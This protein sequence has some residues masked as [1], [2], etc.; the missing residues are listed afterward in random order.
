MPVIIP[1]VWAIPDR[2]P[3]VAHANN[4]GIVKPESAIRGED[5]Q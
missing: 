5:A 1:E 2:P 4:M 3:N